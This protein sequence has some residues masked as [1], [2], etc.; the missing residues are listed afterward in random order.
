M[1]KLRN[2]QETAEAEIIE[3]LRNLRL[4]HTQEPKEILKNRLWHRYV[5]TLIRLWAQNILKSLNFSCYAC[6]HQRIWCFA[7]SFE[8]KFQSSLIKIWK[9]R[10]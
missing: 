10:L 6:N 1:K 2:F 5:L 7:D 4:K 9:N 3:I 8:G